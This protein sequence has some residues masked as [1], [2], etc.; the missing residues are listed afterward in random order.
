[1]S[2][3]NK[4]PKNG[5][6]KLDWGIVNAIRRRYADP[7]ESVTQK[8][9]AIEYDISQG[10]VSSVI[11]N[12]TWRVTGAVIERKT[13][14]TIAARDLHDARRR[15]IQDLKRHTKALDDQRDVVPAFDPETW[16]HIDALITTFDTYFTQGGG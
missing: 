6:A 5:R 12:R 1:M 13:A 10:V 3:T 11:T 14:R 4:G 8:E 15:T 7:F 16:A 2:S 9:L